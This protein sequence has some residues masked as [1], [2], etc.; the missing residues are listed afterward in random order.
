MWPLLLAQS[1]KIAENRDLPRRTPNKI[2]EGA[3]ALK[4]ADV[5]VCGG[6]GGEK[7]WEASSIEQGC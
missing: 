2:C 6:G 5:D 7:R 3:G 1:E 4:N